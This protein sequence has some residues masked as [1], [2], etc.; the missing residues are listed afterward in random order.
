ML[1]ILSTGRQCRHGSECSYLHAEN[2]K[3]D[4]PEKYQVTLPTSSSVSVIIS[5]AFDISYWVPRFLFV[6]L[7]QN[8]TSSRATQGN[9]STYHGHSEE[10]TV[11]IPAIPLTLYMPLSRNSPGASAG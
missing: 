4:C 6:V 2:R 7:L 11:A 8:S 5:T 1:H 10:T 9:H 3:E